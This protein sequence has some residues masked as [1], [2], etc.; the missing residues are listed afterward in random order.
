M[1][2]WLNNQDF[3]VQWSKRNTLSPEECGVAHKVWWVCA[4]GHEWEAMP[5]DR[6]RGRGCPYCAHC[7]PSKEYNLAVCYP[8]LVKEWD[9]RNLCSPSDVLPGSSHKYWWNCQFGHRWQ[10]SINNRAK[11][12][13]CPY[14][15]GFYATPQNSIMRFSNLV[16]EFN[17]EKNIGLDINRITGGSV[18]KLWWKCVNGHEWQASPNMRTRGRGCPHCNKKY[19]DVEIRLWAEAKAVFGNAQWSEKIDGIEVDVYLPSLNIGIE[20]DGSYWH[21]DK[22]DKDTEKNRLLADKGIQI[23]RLREKPL[24]LI[25]ENDIGCTVGED[26]LTV[27]KRVFKKIAAIKNIDIWW[28]LQGTSFVGEEEYCKKIEQVQFPKKSVIDTNPEL[29]SEW[30]MEKNKGI[31]LKSFSFRSNKRVWWKCDKGHEWQAVVADRTRG[32]SGNCQE[33]RKTC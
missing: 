1:K 16:S 20:A 14:C 24:P 33:C 15:C 18:R 17:A 9:M 3:I 26:R 30:N 10:S 11:G 32:R 19:S 22:T 7:L 2:N 8:H 25:S 12:S 21:K 5:A 4:L 13:G 27:V 28:Y 23:I 31:T 29:A 6:I